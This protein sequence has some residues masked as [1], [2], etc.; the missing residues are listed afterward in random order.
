MDE[1]YEKRCGLLGMEYCP[2]CGKRLVS[3]MKITEQF[4][5]TGINAKVCMNFN[6][7]RFT[8]IANLMTWKKQPRN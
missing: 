6:C 3:L 8:Q 7:W 2:D 1:Q 5:V 4:A